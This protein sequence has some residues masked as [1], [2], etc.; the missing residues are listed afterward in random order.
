VTDLC[1][2]LRCDMEAFAWFTS[3]CSWQNNFKK[4]ES[5]ILVFCNGC[6]D[7]VIN[8][9]QDNLAGIVTSLQSE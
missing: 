4:Y 3:S 2:I 8:W 5:L 9:E 7:S 6:C 1:F